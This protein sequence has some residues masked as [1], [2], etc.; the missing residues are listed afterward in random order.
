MALLNT[1]ISFF[2]SNRL[3]QINQFSQRADILQSEQLK[4]LL[5]KAAYTVF[6][7][8]YQFATIENYRQ[9][10]ERVPVV[11]YEEF[12]PYIER[13][14][15]GER[16]VSW[17]GMVK[18]FA[19]SSG[20]T[21]AKS[22]FIP[23]TKEALEN[24]HYRGA[25][26]VVMI[27]ND[28]HPD[29]QMLSGKCLTLGGSKKISKL[30]E[31]QTGDLSAIL[32][33]NSPFWSQFI[34]TPAPKIALLDEWEEKLKLITS[35]TVTENV[36]SLAG[37][38]SWFLVLLKHILK[39]TGK[40]DIHEIWPNL[41][42]FI[43]GGINFTPYREQYRSICSKGLNFM[44][45]Y[46]ASEGFFAIQ[47]DPMDSGL[48]LMLDYGVFYEFVP[49]SE[50]GTPFPTSYS[51]AEVDMHTDYAMVI[52]T[53]GGLWRYMIGDTVRFTSLNP[54]KVIITGRTKH[55]INAFGEELMI[56]NA[57]KALAK[58]CLTTGAVIKEYTAAPIFMNETERGCHQWLIEFEKEPDSEEKFVSVLDDMLRE[59]NSDYEAKRYKD[60]TLQRPILTRAR[61]GLFFDWLKEKGKLGG[62]NK[63]PR[64]AN[65]REYID[66]LLKINGL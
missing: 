25:K 27:Y 61:Q 14:V 46:N 24:C 28:L 23:V 10:K 18:W 22:K 48:Q 17:P 36:T 13:M 32:I 6:G 34:K 3:N 26:D 53:N 42:L 44:E 60:I 52:T 7:R 45:T 9:F 39:E 50:M 16:D 43:H 29:T 5:D 38:P 41:E 33:G 65:N 62:Q 15:K 37:V 47:T 55:Y 19:K 66:V 31:S 40:N 30:G 4:N 21:N 56:D 20:T 49:L 8:E 35:T 54:H 59:L 58:A 51:I 1:I 11:G 57:E 2:T 64:L 12:A 63:I